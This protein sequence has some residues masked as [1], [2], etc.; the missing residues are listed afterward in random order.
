MRD[1]HLTALGLFRSGHRALTAL[2]EE[3]EALNDAG[4]ATADAFGRAQAKTHVAGPDDDEGGAGPVRRGVDAT[5]GDD[6]GGHGFVA[7]GLGLEYGAKF[8]GIERHVF[9]EF[10]IHEAFV[11]RIVGENLGGQLGPEVGGEFREAATAADGA[12]GI[13]GSVEGAK[14]D[15]VLAREF[16]EEAIVGVVGPF[17]L[18]VNFAGEGGEVDFVAIVA[19]DGGLVA[20]FEWFE[21]KNEWDFAE[22]KF[23]EQVELEVVVAFDGVRFAHENDAGGGQVG[24]NIGV[25]NFVAVDEVEPEFTRGEQGGRAVNGGRGGS[26]AG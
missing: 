2:G 23:L 24:E 11:N 22:E 8:R 10:E 13:G 18:P 25:G 17:F 1:G 15:V 21:T 14:R 26:R 19:V 7:G 9:R 16:A 6:V 4:I 5:G 20:G 12:N 3:H